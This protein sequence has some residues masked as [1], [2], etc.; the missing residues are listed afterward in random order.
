LK[1]LINVVIRLASPPVT[2]VNASRDASA[3]EPLYGA[4]FGQAVQR[5][6]TR[7]ARF[8]GMSSRSEYW[9]VVLF[10]L[11][12]ALVLGIL[13]T[14]T[15]NSTGA[16]AVTLIVELALLIPNLSIQWRRLH[17]AGF[18]G[19]WWFLTVIPVIGSII[20]LIMCL[21]PTNPAK[22]KAVWDDPRRAAQHVHG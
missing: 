19:P 11:I 1:G 16:N 8:K 2:T 17:D 20:V 18:A 6:F 13:L 22:Q 9:W 12:I 21:M 15:D 7:Y 5:F 14:A 4:S 10:Q 3:A